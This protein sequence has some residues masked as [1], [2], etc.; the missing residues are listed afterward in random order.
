MQRRRRQEEAGR[1]G[2]RAKRMNSSQWDYVT[3]TNNCSS[4]SPCSCD[5][6]L[7]L[8]SENAWESLMSLVHR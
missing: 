3:L 2:R 7:W 1:G 6:S 5:F 8:K 4:V